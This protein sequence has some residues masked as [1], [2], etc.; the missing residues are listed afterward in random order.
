MY[1]DEDGIA[2][3]RSQALYDARMRIL[4]S[5]TSLLSWLGFGAAILNGEY[6]GDNLSLEGFEFL[7][8]SKFLW[9]SCAQRRKLHCVLS[10]GYHW[11][12][13]PVSLYNAGLQGSLL[14]ILIVSSKLLAKDPDNGEPSFAVSLASSQRCAAILLV[15]IQVLFPR[16]PDLFTPEGKLVDLERSSSAF[17]RYS[18]QWCTTAL[19]LAGKPVPPEELHVL[20]YPTRSKSQPLIVIA[21]SEPTLWDHILAERYLGFVKQW[22]LMFVRSIVTFGSPYCVMR[23]LKSL[24][25]NHGRT[26][27]AWIW[28]IGVGL[29][30]VCQT[31]I[32]YHLIWIQWSE[33]GIPLRAQ[34][35]MAIFQKVLRRKDS[36]DQKKSSDPK[37]ARSKPEAINLISSDTL[38]LSK[39]S[40]VNY[41]LPS[42][43]VRFFFAILFLLKLLGW[44]STLVGM[45]VTVLCVP[46]HT[47]VIKQQRAAQKNL[48]A[49][50]DKKA[51]VVTEAL[52]ALRQIKFS[53]LEAQWEEHIET[54][55]QEE[56]KHLRWSFTASSIRSVWGV[57]APFAV[58]AASVCTYARLQGAITPSTIFPMIEV[59]PHLEGTL[60]F[61]PVVFQDY[62]GAR[63][64]ASRIGEFLRRGEQ[65]RILGPSPSGNISF[66]NASIAWPS[67]NVEGEASLEK[68]DTSSHRFSLHGINLEFPV[69]ELSVISGKTGSGKSLL[70]AAMIGEVEILGGRI[71]A[72]SM[73]EG[74]PVAFVSQTPWLQNATIRDNILFGNPFDKERYEKVLTACALQPDLVAL[75]KGDETQIGLRGVKLSGGQ[76]ARLAFG[77][78]LYSNAKLLVLDD[79]FSALDSHV[80]KQI[81]NA[82]TDELGKG[83]TRILVTHQVSLCIPKTKYIVHLQNNTIG[84]A[85]NTDSIEKGVDVVEA[86]VHLG[87]KPS[88][89]EKQKANASDKIPKKRL[90][91][92]KAQELNARADLN[93][94]KSYFAA[95]GG[96]GFTVIYFL[97][98]VTKQLLSALT[99]WLPGR[100]N[101]TRS[102]GISDQPEKSPPLFA[103]A[104][105]GL[106]QY[107]YL[108]IWSL[109][110]AITLESLFNLHTFSGSI[111]ASKYLFREITSRI[112]RMP[113]LWLDT[114]PIGEMLRA[115][116]LDTRLVDDLLLVT[117]SEF[118][119]CFVQLLTI[120]G[121]GLYTSK[122]TS[123]LTVTLLFWCAQ[124]SRD[125]I[126][127]RSTVKRADAVPTADILE[128]F[129]SSAAGVSTIRAFGAVDKSVEQM[130]RHIDRLSTARR[131]FWIFNRWLGLQMS[132]IGILFS[133]GTGII[134]LSSN[135]IIDTS[136]VGFS[137][138]FSMRFSQAIFKAVNNFGILESYIG[139]AGSII[140]YTEL[141][142][143]EQGGNEVSEDWPSKGEVEVKGLKAAYSADLPLV[144]KD[145]SFTVGAGQRIGIVGRTGAGK[146]SLTLSL[147]RLLEPRGGSIHIDGIDISTIKLKSLRSRIAFIPQDPVLFSGTVRSNLDY[148]KQ[149]P[150]NKLKEALRRVKLLAEEGDGKSG[151]FTLN[152]PISAGGANM[153]QGQRQLLCLARVLIK[154]PKII[155]LDEATSAVDNKTD[156]LIQDTIRIEFGG[157]LIVVAHRLRT[158]APFDQVMV[159]DDGKVAEYGTPAELLTS[160][161]LFYDLVQDSQDKEFLTST[162]L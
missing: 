31:I 94:Y 116:T 121:V 61:V 157:T 15:I 129:T 140:R 154:N 125:Y 119:D 51:K 111:R 78:A 35:I 12:E 135:S 156:L 58:A 103:N 92:K 96:L 22:T 147:L 80:S 120:V 59:L 36:K 4:L 28:L 148:F 91:A 139:A 87:P 128:H 72:P 134:L 10:L 118:A 76:R 160:K 30:S 98:L 82:L 39:F 84:Y 19:A 70:L 110:L 90:T 114:T 124:V 29:F 42:S 17:R 89:E 43:F 20:D 151:L 105:S 75:A 26:D 143:E 74:H 127:A 14:S 155:I 2:T 11:K 33:M 63:S 6:A 60:G 130:H 117:M 46:V 24:E 144:L 50:R 104:G 48:T 141:E 67:D 133:T 38:S 77:R 64:N 86:E 88:T 161:G 106:Q 93:V 95:A 85:G 123:F 8:W 69:G 45:T 73:A 55:R 13:N 56:I 146:S 150:E 16:R 138:T 1:S 66:Q 81:F 34:L 122:Y 71:D 137:L 142:T 47:F 132:F 97:G 44:Q 153:S 152:S 99:T 100:I 54:F 131:H 18:M 52:H 102:R 7:R 162:I 53:A 49:A 126:K 115:F 145:V 21:S 107:L 113:I 37:V 149:V 9:A 5:T 79:I 159:M 32:N 158:I 27:D 3:K 25:D 136:L 108:Y 68:Q 62:F 57:A 112:I 23:L 101:S 65:E 83:R 109:L 41:I 40:A